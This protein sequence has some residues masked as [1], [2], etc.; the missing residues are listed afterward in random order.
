MDVE[1]VAERDAMRQREAEEARL[2]SLEGKVDSPSGKGLDEKH[3]KDL[4]DRMAKREV[5]QRDELDFLKG[6]GAAHRDGRVTPDVPDHLNNPDATAEDRLKDLERRANTAESAQEDL[7][8]ARHGE[9]DARTHTET[10]R[11][12]DPGALADEAD[13]LHGPTSPTMPVDPANKR[14]DPQVE[15][16]P[17]KAPAPKKPD[18]PP[19]PKPKPDAARARARDDDKKR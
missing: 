13:A 17:A 15:M 11:P 2:R 14:T 4:E 7:D 5:Q 3:L 16:E 19:A 1:R 8:R 9:A 12:R 18:L 6:E 10:G